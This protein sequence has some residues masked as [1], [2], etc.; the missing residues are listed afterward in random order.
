MPAIN[1][2]QSSYLENSSI[3]EQS[4]NG[5]DFMP[6]TPDKNDENRPNKKAEI[7]EKNH[8]T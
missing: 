1:E 8:D 2:E 7:H 6:Q 3:E 5:S 4:T